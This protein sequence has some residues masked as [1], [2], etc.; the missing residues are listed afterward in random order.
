MSRRKKYIYSPFKKHFWIPFTLSL[1]IFFSGLVMKLSST[2]ETGYVKG[3]LSG[4][5]DFVFTGEGVMVLGAA[6]CLTF[7]FMKRFLK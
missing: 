3:R 6:L 4:R 7:V 1:V 5:M 2:T